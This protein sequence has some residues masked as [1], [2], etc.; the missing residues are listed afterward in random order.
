MLFIELNNFFN[1]KENHW[2]K[3]NDMD[4]V[5]VVLARFFINYCDHH[6]IY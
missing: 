2:N 1:G 3:S 5:E 4:K 6:L